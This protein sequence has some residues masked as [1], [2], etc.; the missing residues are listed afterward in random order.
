VH[1]AGLVHRD[2]KPAN[3]MITPGDGVKLMDLGI[4]TGPT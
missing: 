3:I 2:V 4:A 1:D